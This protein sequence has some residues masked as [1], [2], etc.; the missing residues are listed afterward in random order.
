[1]PGA[2][3]RRQGQA[4]LSLNDQAAVMTFN[5]RTAQVR[6][7]PGLSPSTSPGQL[8]KRLFRGKTNEMSSCNGTPGVDCH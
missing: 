3:Q 1:M 8:S 5:A 2:G 6:H 7:G 4:T